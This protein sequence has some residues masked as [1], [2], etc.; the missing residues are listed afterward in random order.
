MRLIPLADYSYD[1]DDYRFRYDDRRRDDRERVREDNRQRREDR[2]EQESMQRN[3][4]MRVSL[5]DI[6]NDPDIMMMDSGEIRS[7]TKRG[8]SKRVLYPPLSTPK[9][10]TR[11]KRGND[12]KLSKAFTMA[13]AKLRTKKGAL[14]KGK[15]QADVAR[16]AHRIK[17][18]L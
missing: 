13:N 3:R 7:V 4:D 17:K 8:N 16:L 14:R 6:I 15:T 9:R 12:K 1:R 5:Q 18:R 10:K 11:K 2:D